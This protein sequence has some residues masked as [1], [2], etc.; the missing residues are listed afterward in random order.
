MLY[1][2]L[3]LGVDSLSN[4]LAP[5]GTSLETFV[6]QDVT[7]TIGNRMVKTCLFWFAFLKTQ[8]WI[9][10]KMWSFEANA[11]PI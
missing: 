11:P 2:H 1:S 10:L 3:L 9:L 4:A 8:G 6:V 7:G 5:R